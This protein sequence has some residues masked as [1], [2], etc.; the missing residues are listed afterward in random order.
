MKTKVTAKRIYL[1][2]FASLTPVAILLFLALAA[3]LLSPISKAQDVIPEKSAD[4]AAA[5]TTPPSDV[6]NVKATAGNGQVVLNWNVATDNIGVKGYKIYYGT[7]AVVNDGDTYTSGPIDAGNKITYTVTGLNNGTT[8]YF[9]VTAYDAANNE[10][11]NYSVEASATPAHAA[12]DSEAPK[13]LKA[14]AVAKNTVKVT[15]SEGV[16]L[17]LSNPESAFNIKNDSN[18]VALAVTKMVTDPADVTKKTVLLT[19]ATQQAGASYIL[20]AGIQIKD[21]M[22]NPIVSGTS[23]TAVFTGTDIEPPA[24]QQTVQTQ[25]ADKVAP[26]LVDLKV[27]SPTE[28]NVTF[29]EAIVTGSDPTQNFIITEEDNIENTLN[30]T[31]V[32]MSGQGKVATLTTAPQKP[33]NYNLIVVDVTDKSG[34]LISADNN[35]TV[36]FGA[37]PGGQPTQQTIQTQETQATEQTSQINDTTPPEDAT[38][39]IA[40]LV[41]KIVKLSWAASANSDGDL[42]NYILYQSTDGQTYDQGVM[43]NPEAKSFDLSSLMPG[44]KYFFKLTAKDKNGNESVGVQTTFIL[45]ETGPEIIFLALGSLGLGKLFSRKKKINK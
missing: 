35:A 34:N 19:T 11:G 25:A 41:K 8:Y 29:S 14:E 39:F 44:I 28:I 13:V 2:H 36:F 30:I 3:L 32:V 33:M 18:Q 4:V 43:I 20:I 17:P 7:K 9:A 38:N 5:D 31:K 10:S 27:L 6:E 15:F 42:L 21:L 12:A 16:T 26:E 24:T 45:P 23:D 1:S 40:N 22:G 37:I